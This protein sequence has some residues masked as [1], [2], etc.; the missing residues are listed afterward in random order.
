MTKAA[1]DRARR[2]EGPTFIEAFTYRMGAHTTSDDPTRY[3][4]AAEVEEWKLKDPIARLKV[5]LLSR[6]GLAEPGVLRA[7]S[8]ARPTS[9]PRTCA[10]ACLAMPDPDPDDMFASPTREPHPLVGRGA[11]LVRGLPRQLRRAPVTPTCTG[12]P[13]EPDR[14]TDDDRQGDQR[15]P[16]HGD[17]GRPEGPR[18]GRGRRQARRGLPGH[19]R[20]AEGLRRGPGDRHPARRERHHRHRDRPG[21]ARLPAGLRDPVR[22]V[23]LPRLRPDRLPA[24]ED[25]E[26][27]ARARSGCRWSSGCRSAAASAR[28]STTARAPRRTSP[29]PRGCGRRPARI[30]PTPTG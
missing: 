23:H 5:H 15:G 16:A 10:T 6:S 18:D 20:P 7:R 14:Q 17:G 4:I 19:R 1:L 29:T 2:G 3:R 9:S 25:G 11:G 12:V 30:P 22:R 21:P 26:P 24:G 28:S 8:S 13:D 27:L